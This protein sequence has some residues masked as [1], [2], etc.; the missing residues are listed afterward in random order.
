MSNITTILGKPKSG[1]TTRLMEMA[2]LDL[3][4]HRKVLF[5]GKEKEEAVRIRI[6]GLAGCS[7]ENG[8]LTVRDNWL[9]PLEDK[10]V[11]FLKPNPSVLSSVYIDDIFISHV[12]CRSIVETYR[13]DLIKAVTERIDAEWVP[14]ERPSLRSL[15]QPAPGDTPVPIEQCCFSENGTRC[16]HWA[17][18]EVKPV[19]DPNL[20]L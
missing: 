7:V 12:A 17:T 8:S 13:V 11:D 19:S 6:C 9:S 16:R 15:I 2:G 20:T 14:P 3:R 5:I 1:K 18:F 10:I 4:S